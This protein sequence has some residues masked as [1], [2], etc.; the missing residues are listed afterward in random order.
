MVA[1]LIVTGAPGAGKSSVL[2]ELGTR[3]EIAGQ[4]YGS[5]ESEQLA[6]GSPLLGD[7]EWIPQLAAVLRLQREAGRRLFLIAA[8]PESE[9]ALRDVVEA[10]G[11]DR[12]LVVCLRSDPETLAERLD[13]RES[14]RW[15]GKQPLID[16][17]R[18][19]ADRIPAFEGVDLVL[20]TDSLA[21]DEVVEGIL[22]ALAAA[23]MYIPP[24]ADD[25]VPAP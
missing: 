2:V 6:Q 8:T 19:L 12:T 15:P 21:R 16:R 4:S 3:L 14:S 5:I 20:D 23:E 10:V 1:A 9:A 22:G 25:H 7:E 18:D 11:G 24:A 17:A 13:Q